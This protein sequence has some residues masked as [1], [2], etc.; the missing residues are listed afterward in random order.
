[1][2]YRLIKINREQLLCRKISHFKIASQMWW[3]LKHHSCEIHLDLN[4]VI[5]ME[6]VHTVR[7]RSLLIN[8]QICFPCRKQKER[9]S[10]SLVTTRLLLISTWVVPKIFR[11]NSS[12]K[13]INARSKRRNISLRIRF[14]RRTRSCSPMIS[15]RSQKG[16]I[17]LLELPRIV[18]CKL[19][20]NSMMVTASKIS[21]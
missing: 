10:S 11:Q 20:S 19:R 1:M 7:F 16:R 15:W 3:C 14:S 4:R 12:V 13:M 5:S 2:A 9:S 21:V 8:S 17:R 18:T 6:S